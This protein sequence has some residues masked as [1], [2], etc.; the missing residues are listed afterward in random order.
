[1]LNN[2]HLE[3]ISTSM[4]LDHG[5]YQ[6]LLHTPFAPARLRSKS[7]SLIVAGDLQYDLNAIYNWVVFNSEKFHYISFSSSLSSNSYNV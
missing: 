5:V 2:Q 6:P 7:T 3:P 4:S 1:M